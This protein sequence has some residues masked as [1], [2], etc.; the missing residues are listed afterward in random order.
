MYET[1]ER[2]FV[3]NGQIQ[4]NVSLPRL[5][6]WSPWSTCQAPTSR[7]GG[8]GSVASR[9]DSSLASALRSLGTRFV[10][11]VIAISVGKFYLI[12]LSGF[13]FYKSWYLFFCR[14]HMGWI[15][16]IAAQHYHTSPG[17]KTSTNNDMYIVQCNAISQHYYLWLLIHFP[18]RRN[19]DK[20]DSPSEPTKP[21]LRKHGKLITFFRWETE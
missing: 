20:S 10:F 16:P 21:V 2:Y 6:T 14:F 18:S 9:S 5:A 13:Y 7:S 4:I 1:F 15:F 11:S 12:C 8:E 3:W 17:L 19:S